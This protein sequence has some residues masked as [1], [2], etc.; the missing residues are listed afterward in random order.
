MR[1]DAE[2]LHG[3]DVGAEIDFAGQ[4]AM[5]TAMARQE[6]YALAFERCRVTMASDG[7]P[8]GVLTRISRVSGE[9]RPWSRDPLPPMM[10]IVALRAAFAV[11]TTS[12]ICHSLP[13]RHFT[14]R[15]VCA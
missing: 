15:A 4:D 12:S 5:A 8:K 9:A 11:R 10:P 3:V 14:R 6:G 2:L 7:S 1:C 13:L